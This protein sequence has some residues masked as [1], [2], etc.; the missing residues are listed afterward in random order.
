MCGAAVMAVGIGISAR[1]LRNIG[2]YMEITATL[3][4]VLTQ[5]RD[6]KNI[7]ARIFSG[8]LSLY[9]ITGYV[10][11]VLSYSR[12]MAL[13]LATGV[14][15]SVVNILG[16]LGGN[17][18]LG[19]FV[20]VLIALFGHSLNFAIN[21]LGAYVHT[22]RLQYVEFYQKFYEGGGRKFTPFKMDTKYYEFSKND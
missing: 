12:L 21:M 13:G 1:H 16:S 20:F 14:I 8:I 22:N 6:K 19:I 3:G 5:G 18:P 11:D 15:A 7:F 10:G 9:D 4:L 17:S 2:I